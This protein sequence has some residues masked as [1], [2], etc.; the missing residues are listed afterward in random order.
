MPR[1]GR[2]DGRPGTIGA[3]VELLGDVDY[4][5]LFVLALGRRAVRRQR[6]GARAPAGRRD[7]RATS[8]GPRGAAASLMAVVGLIAAVWALASLAR[9]TDEPR[10]WTSPDLP[11][12][13][14]L[15]ARGRPAEAGR[16]AHHHRRR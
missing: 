15:P 11:A 4:L 7:R 6:A 14:G 16:A 13:I 8:S 5:P 2:A 9:M 3:Q 10:R 1:A 12:Q